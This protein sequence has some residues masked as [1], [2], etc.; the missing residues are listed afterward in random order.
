MYLI[1][2]LCDELHQQ[3][4]EKHMHRPNWQSY[5]LIDSLFEIITN[6]HNYLS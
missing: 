6:P 5:Y 3:Q 1:I 4:L 2:Y